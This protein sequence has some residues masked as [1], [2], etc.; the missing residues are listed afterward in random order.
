M[1]RI[2]VVD[3]SPD[4]LAI[5]T[6]ALGF[7][8]WEVCTATCLASAESQMSQPPDLIL[9]DCQLPDGDG[10]NAARRWKENPATAS[11]PIAL[12]TG[13]STSPPE[14]LFADVIVKT[15]DPFQLARR[16]HRILG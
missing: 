14:G 9:L 2:L 4:I 8:G 15:V 5:L 1:K 3:D 16:L 12:Y 11:I 13:T 7:E 6:A 10:L